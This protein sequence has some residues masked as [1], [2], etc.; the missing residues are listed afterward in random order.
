M[1]EIKYERKFNER[2]K[3]MEMFQ[4]FKHMEKEEKEGGRGR[5]DKIAGK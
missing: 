4:F 1:K 5:N 2:G 3:V